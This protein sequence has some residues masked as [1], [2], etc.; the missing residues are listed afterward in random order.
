M[1][2]KHKFQRLAESIT[3]KRCENCK[4][5]KGCFCNS[6]KNQKCANSIFPIGWEKKEGED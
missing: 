1:S 6:V 3:G 4:H 5:H 2:L